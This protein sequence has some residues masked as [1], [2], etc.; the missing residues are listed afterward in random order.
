MTID[1]LFNNESYD[2]SYF[3]YISIGCIKVFYPKM[4]SSLKNTKTNIFR[5]TKRKALSKYNLTAATD[6]KL[7]RDNFA[8]TLASPQMSGRLARCLSV[9]ILFPEQISETRGWISLILRI[10]YN[11]LHLRYYPCVFDKFSSFHY[12][13]IFNPFT[14]EFHIVIFIHHKPRIAVAR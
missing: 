5:R 2:I 7:E 4:R 14:P 9:R 11:N 12:L 1:L 8:S 13:V 10:F 6:R 3:R